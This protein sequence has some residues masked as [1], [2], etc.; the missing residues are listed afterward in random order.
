MK[1]GKTLRLTVAS[2]GAALSF[3]LMYLGVVSGIL[4]MSASVICGVLTLIMLRECGA[5]LTLISTVVCTVLCAVLIH[6][7]TVWLLYLTVGGLYPLVK[8]LLDRWNSI[9]SWVLK[10]AF[11]VG[12]ALL[13]IL[14]T[15]IF[16]PSAGALMMI[17]VG[18]PLA[19]FCF[20]LYDVLLTR[21]APLYERRIRHLFVKKR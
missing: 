6:D 13:Y 4:D 2:M 14:V 21:I 1:E 5:K 20:V 18:V 16:I 3:A 8:G 19:V 11:A 9:I 7:K 15:L 10:L 17:P 12:T